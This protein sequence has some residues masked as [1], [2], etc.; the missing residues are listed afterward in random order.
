MVK[1]GD[2]VRLKPGSE[3]RG[4]LEPWADDVWRVART[5][6]DDDDDGLH[7][8]IALGD[9]GVGHTSPLPADEFELDRSP[10]DGAR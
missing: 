3:L 7:I 4:L 2:A 6:Q 8:A 10:V 1:I 5:Y 9:L